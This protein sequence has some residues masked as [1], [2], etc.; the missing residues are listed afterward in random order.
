MSDYP[1]PTL[2]PPPSP[3]PADRFVSIALY[4]WVLLNLARSRFW[5]FVTALFLAALL[6]VGSVLGHRPP[7]AVFGFALS[8]YCVARLFGLLGPRPLRCVDFRAV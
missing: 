1:R 5:A 3:Y 2:S 8:I 4:G 6:T 7:N